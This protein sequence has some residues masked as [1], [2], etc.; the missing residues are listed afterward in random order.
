MASAGALEESE[1][2]RASSKPLGAIRHDMPQLA[3]HLADR[4][5]RGNPDAHLLQTTLDKALQQKMEQAVRSAVANLQPGLSVALILADGKS[6][7]ILAEVGSPDYLSVER[8]GWI[9]MSRASR[10]PGS[11]LKPFIYGLAFEEGLIQGRNPDLGQA[12]QFRWL[13]TK[14][15]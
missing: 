10:S 5:K 7:T 4:L 3:P 8:S 15:F 2:L 6:G 14:E 13:P 11:A 12:G 9:D 1:V